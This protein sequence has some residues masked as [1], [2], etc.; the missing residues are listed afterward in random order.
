MRATPQD[1]EVSRGKTVDVADC[2]L[3]TTPGAFERIVREGLV[4]GAADFVSGQIKTNN[5]A[6]LLTMQKLF[7]LN[8]PTSALRSGTGERRRMKVWPCGRYRLL[9]SPRGFELRPGE[10]SVR[11]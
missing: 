4:P 2:V 1:V 8:V 6:H 10:G 7:Q 9:G 3:K 11:L 5:V